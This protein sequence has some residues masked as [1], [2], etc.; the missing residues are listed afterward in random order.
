[1]SSLSQTLPLLPPRT[2]PYGNILVHFCAVVLNQSNK[3]FPERQEIKIRLD[4]SEKQQQHTLLSYALKEHSA[5][6]SL[7][8]LMLHQYIISDYIKNNCS[9]VKLFV[10]LVYTCLLCLEHFQ[11][12]IFEDN[13]T[14][15]LS[16]YM[17]NFR[18]Y[19][20]VRNV[21]CTRKIFSFDNY[22]KAMLE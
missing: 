1:M 14:C 10:Q 11:A 2:T 17:A 22:S 15:I 4:C 3:F 8:F 7:F 9:T 5:G 20:T 16:I 12:S 21:I 18:V 6:R 19:D 13:L